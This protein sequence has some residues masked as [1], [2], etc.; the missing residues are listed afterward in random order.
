L[1]I[2]ILGSEGF[3][4]HHLVEHFIK[5][6]WQVEG[7]DLMEY[8]SSGYNYH[9]VSILSPDFESIFTGGPF[10]VCIN[11][12][13]SGNVGYS[14][15]HPQSDF[16]VNAN[17]VSRALDAVRKQNSACRFLHISSAAVYGNPKQ[18]P[19]VESAPANPVSP[20]GFHKLISELICKEYFDIY[21]IPIAIVRPFSVFGNG[22]K[23]QLLWDL[24]QKLK[25][26]D[27]VN[28]FGTGNETRD[29]IH[30]SDFVKAVECIIQKSAF[31]LDIYN[32]ASGKATPIKTVARIFEKKIPGKPIGFSGEVKPGDPT[33]WQA[34]ISAIRKIGFEPEAVFDKSVRDYIDWQSKIYTTS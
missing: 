24:C 8:F 32:L 22:L 27:E 1:K 25:N 33:Q 12:S 15:L 28:L 10:D 26:A 17:A 31:E 5:K 20:Y 3:I 13:G 9:K 7:C 11:A 34:D 4:G 2:L 18:L 14:I 29:F 6:G 23:K 30:I 19:V 21:K 16:D